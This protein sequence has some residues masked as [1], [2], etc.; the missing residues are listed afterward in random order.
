MLEEGQV[1]KVALPQFHLGVLEVVVMGDWF[2][3]LAL[4]IQAVVE[5]ADQRVH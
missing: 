1:V 4:Q 5:V 2:Q 3:L